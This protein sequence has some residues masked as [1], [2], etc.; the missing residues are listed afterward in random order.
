MARVKAAAF[1]LLVVAASAPASRAEQIGFASAAQPDR[2]LTSDWS[3][4]FGGGALAV[5]SYPGAASTKV[6]PLPFVDVRYGD[7]VFLSPIAGLGVNLIV[8]PEARLGLAVLPDLGRNASSGD[9]LRGWGDLGAGADLKLSGE[10]RVLGPL[11]VLAS[12]RRQFGAG[13]GTVV[14]AG[15][16]G[17]LPLMRRLILSATGT[18]TWANARYTRSYFGVDADQSA[19]ALAFG[20]AVRTF[21]AGAGLRDVSLGLLAIVPIDRH[22][23]VQSVTR[24]EVLLGDAASSPLTQRRFQLTFGGFLAYKL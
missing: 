10:L 19:A 5:P 8:V 13:N 16:N 1:A 12:A 22:W 11:A 6:I 14:D 15:L 2:P 9:R 3:F 4:V 17:T 21:A 7:R 18:V 24:T 20:S 23:S